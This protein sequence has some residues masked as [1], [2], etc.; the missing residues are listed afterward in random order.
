M[1]LTDQKMNFGPSKR[2]VHL[3]L[4]LGATV[5]ALANHPG[6]ATEPRT[7]MPRVVVTTTIVADLVRQVAGDE[8]ETDCLMGPGVD[9]HSFKATPR[10]ADRLARADLVV[11][12]GLHLEGK[13][14]ALLERLGQRK[15]VV[16][17]A[18]SIPKD[19]LIEVGKGLYDPHVWFDPTLWAVCVEAVVEPLG[20]IVPAG[21]PRFEAAAAKY[22]ERLEHLD[23]ALR[24]RVAT[25]PQQRRVLVTSHDAFR[26]FGRA[27]GLEVVGI[28]GMSTESEAGLND[29]N[30]LV[31]L[32]VSR[33]VPAVFVETSVADRNVTALREG[34]RAKGH[35]V[36]L[37]GRL[38]SD[39]LGGPQ[40]GAETLEEALRAN[41]DVVVDGLAGVAERESDGD[42]GS[43]R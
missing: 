43:G 8:V 14:A 16:S 24:A 32:V 23:D 22:R 15:R 12:S 18:E 25:I 2:P 1:L 11:A 37:G 3:S 7:G 39:A 19:R 36:R 34:A 29:V 42:E 17:V 38:Y 13:L 26:Y 10:D 27:Y 40:S 28:Q 20:H 21:R 5:A 31:D 33:G 41:V 30:R 9:P 35:G 4:V 6:W